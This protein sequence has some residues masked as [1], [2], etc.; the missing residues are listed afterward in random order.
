MLAPGR[1]GRYHRHKPE[2]VRAR[3]E[4]GVAQPG[5]AP[6]MGAEVVGS[7]PSPVARFASSQRTSQGFP[8][9]QRSLGRGEVRRSS[10]GHQHP[11]RLG[12]AQTMRWT[13]HTAIAVDREAHERSAAMRAGPA[14]DSAGRGVL[15]LELREK[16]S[17][18]SIDSLTLTHAEVKRWRPQPLN[19]QRKRRR[20][21][22]GGWRAPNE[23]EC[24]LSSDSKVLHFLWEP[25]V[26]HGGRSGEHHVEVVLDLTLAQETGITMQVLLRNAEISVGMLRSD[27]RPQHALRSDAWHPVPSTDDWWR[28]EILNVLRLCH[29]APPISGTGSAGAPAMHFVSPGLQSAGLGSSST[30]SRLHPPLFT[31]ESQASASASRMNMMVDTKY[32]TARLLG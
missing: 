20:K 27:H 19:W 4:R 7:N 12:P 16:P 22:R 24:I 1:E 32:F 3:V 23:L 25:C 28:R 15:L 6:S 9:F 17:D 30:G 14:V 5:R 21:H 2:R 26:R 8:V 18:T 13:D 31:T 10:S 29:R 11:R